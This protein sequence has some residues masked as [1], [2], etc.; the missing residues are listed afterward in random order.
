MIMGRK[1]SEWNS[2]ND[3]LPKLPDKDYCKVM[4]ITCKKGDKDSTPM[5]YERTMIRGERVE[6][7]KYYWDRIAQKPD[8]WME[9]PKP[10]K[11]ETESEEI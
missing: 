9:L 10:P 2:V 3:V 5:I 7:W 1:I 8:F 6:R 11:T 4:V